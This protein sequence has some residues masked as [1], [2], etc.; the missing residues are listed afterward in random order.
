M[1]TKDKFR[2]IRS[3][4]NYANTSNDEEERKLFWLI[5]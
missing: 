3:T 2:V 4:F 1:D 5:S